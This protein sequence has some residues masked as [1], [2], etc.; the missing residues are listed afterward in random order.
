MKDFRLIGCLWI[1]LCGVVFI[2][3]SENGYS[4]W[5]ALVTTVL[6]LYGVILYLNAERRDGDLLRPFP[7]LVLILAIPAFIYI[8]SYRGK[9]VFPSVKSLQDLS[10]RS[11]YINGICPGMTRQ[12]ALA[13]LGPPTSEIR[14][15]YFEQLKLTRTDLMWLAERFPQREFKSET[16]ANLTVLKED[17][18][19]PM[20]LFWSKIPENSQTR[21]PSETLERSLSNRFPKLLALRSSQPEMEE[22][23]ALLKSRVPVEREELII[24]AGEVWHNGN[25]GEWLAFYRRD[26][27]DW[28]EREL[29]VRFTVGPDPVVTSVSGPDVFIETR[30]ILGRGEPSKPI[31]RGNTTR[32]VTGVLPVWEV[33]DHAPDGVQAWKGFEVF[34]DDEPTENGPVITRMTLGFYP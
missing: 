29:R 14:T 9:F 28:K 2:A 22:L 18:G 11:L 3:A 12:Q 21:S 23:I 13:N 25:W 17:F 10:T 15:H 5:G 8:P 1:P 26:V 30:R 27:L 4:A 20:D 31:R 16:H 19:E 32:T 33:E 24:L 6:I 34:T 7:W